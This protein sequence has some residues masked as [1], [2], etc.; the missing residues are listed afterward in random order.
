MPYKNE[1]AFRIKEPSQFDSFA[2]KNNEFGK[3]IHVIYGI[4]AG[5]SQ[6]Q[7]IRFSASKWSF[8]EAKS[9]IDKHNWKYISA[10]EAT[11]TK[12]FIVECGQC[13]HKFDLLAEP[14]VGMGA[15]KCPHCGSIVDQEGTVL[16]A[17]TKNILSRL[18]ARPFRDN[19]NGV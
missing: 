17:G 5:K 13:K 15:T 18:V 7:A 9:W 16:K 11:G 4:K 14:E 10:E 12:G 3:G 2:R 1:H 6:V 8:K 19:R